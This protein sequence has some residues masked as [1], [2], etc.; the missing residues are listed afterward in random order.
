MLMKICPDHREMPGNFC[1]KCGKPLILQTLL[2]LTDTYALEVRGDQSC[3]SCLFDLDH[4][5]QEYCPGCGRKLK[6]LCW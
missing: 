5:H 1:K 3:P 4:D 6:W 2:P